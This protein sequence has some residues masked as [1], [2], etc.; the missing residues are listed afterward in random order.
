MN[1]INSH[2]AEM[3]FDALDEL[4]I[5]ITDGFN[6]KPKAKDKARAVDDSISALE[7]VRNRRQQREQTL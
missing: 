4:L 6:T 1:K 2:E 5:I 7:F 3:L